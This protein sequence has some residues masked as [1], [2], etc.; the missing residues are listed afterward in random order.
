MVDEW[1]INGDCRCKCAMIVELYIRYMSLSSLPT[2]I[3]LIYL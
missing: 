3:P 2:M 1:L